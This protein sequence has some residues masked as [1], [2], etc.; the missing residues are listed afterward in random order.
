M[1]VVRH[2]FDRSFIFFLACQLR[3]KRGGLAPSPNHAERYRGPWTATVDVLRARRAP[4]TCSEI[5]ENAAGTDGPRPS[6][7]FN[8]SGLLSFSFHQFNITC[9]LPKGCPTEAYDFNRKSVN[10]HTPTRV[11]PAPH[12]PADW[13]RP[14]LAR[15]LLTTHADPS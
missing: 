1:R 2:T 9:I 8:W 12:L 13:T 3:E 10:H 7:G 4:N 15:Y 6:Q 14:I 11:C 5:T